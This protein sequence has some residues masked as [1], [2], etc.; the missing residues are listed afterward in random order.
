MTWCVC[1]LLQQC[2]KA[3]T[4]IGPRQRV[5]CVPGVQSLARK[6]RLIATLAWHYGEGAFEL[7]PRSWLLPHQYWQWRLWAEAQVPSSLCILCA[8][9][10]LLCGHRSFGIRLLSICAGCVLWQK[11]TADSLNTV[12]RAES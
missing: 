12:K 8:M 1:R 11:A 3:L 2:E 4:K 9:C 7:T 10:K 5:S 6:A